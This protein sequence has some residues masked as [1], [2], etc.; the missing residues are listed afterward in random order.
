[1]ATTAAALRAR[2]SADPE[3]RFFV[4]MAGFAV[5]V[6]I[7]GFSQRYFLPLAAGTLHVPRIVHLHGLLMWGW[8][9]L[10]FAQSY[11]ACTGQ[12]RRHRAFGMAGI[13][14]MTLCVWTGATIGILQLDDRLVAGMGNDARAFA[15]M[16]LSLVLMM[17]VLFVAAI[18][19][20]RNWEA[21]ARLMLLVTL[22]AL[23][24][25]WARVVGMING[26]RGV[27]NA[28]VGGVI[29]LATIAF[30]MLRDRTKR[31]R[32]HPAYLYGGAFVLGVQLLRTAL[33]ETPGWYALA[34][35]LT[36]LVH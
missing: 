33:N 24:P 17:S 26:T 12:L 6:A 1:M 25:A 4:L 13:A 15:I 31:G 32:A 8:T 2:S 7:F 11:L 19:H 22:V 36:G 18:V 35:A 29:V 20:A 5:F 28:I 27:S 16:P 23:N 30:A 34:D 21:H 9:V 3:R 14:V 10:F